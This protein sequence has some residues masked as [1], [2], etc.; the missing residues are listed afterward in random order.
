M[1]GKLPAT[2]AR[3]VTLLASETSHPAL[4]GAPTMHARAVAGRPTVVYRIRLAEK[5]GR[6]ERS[7]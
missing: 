3:F 5:S 2:E 1:L 7:P 6:Y 4:A